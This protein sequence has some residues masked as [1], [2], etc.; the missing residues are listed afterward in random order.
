MSTAVLDLPAARPAPA[1]RPLPTAARLILK[2]L[3]GTVVLALLF[4]VVGPRAYPFETFYV[5]SGSMAPTIPV[6]S[7]VLATRAPAEKLRVGDVIVFHRPDRPG[8]MVVHRIAAVVTTPN[9]RAFVTKGD[10]NG[11]PDGWDVAATGDGWKAVYSVREAGF[12]VGWLHVALSR[13]GWLGAFS[14]IV[15]LWA[16]ITIWQCEEP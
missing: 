6:G 10:A 2:G 8:T 5:R 16:L 14:V 11:S 15:A 12:V 3:L 13:R 1:I 4:L 7:L 9:G